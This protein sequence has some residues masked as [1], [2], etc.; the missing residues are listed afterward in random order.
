MA[1]NYKKIP[2]WENRKRIKELIEFR[3]N[4]V[5]YFNNLESYTIM[6]V[7]ENDIAKE[8]RAK[9][10]EKLDKI[11]SYFDDTEVHPTLIHRAPPAIGGY[12][13]SVDILVNIFTLHQLPEISPQRILD[14]IDRLIG[15]Y[16]NDSVKAFFRTINPLWWIFLLIEFIASI[17]FKILESA[18]L[19]REKIETS[20]PGKIIKG[21]FELIIVIAALF[22]I[23]EAIGY[24][25]SVLSS[26]KKLLNL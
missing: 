11:H 5:T 15:V 13:E 3:N 17:P 19:N 24:L 21:I 23:L 8:T 25:D 1:K 26:F 12:R 10:N 7:K 16:K 4:I 14:Y 2:I 20:T 9:I 6:G 22:T 18:G